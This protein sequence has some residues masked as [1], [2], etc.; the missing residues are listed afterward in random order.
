[1]T[2]N[3]KIIA[4]LTILIASLNVKAAKLVFASEKTPTYNKIDEKFIKY[5]KYKNQAV[6]Y[7][8]G[9]GITDKTLDF[10]NLEIYAGYKEKPRLW[11][12]DGW[13]TNSYVKSSEYS[14]GHLVEVY[15]AFSLGAGGMRKYKDNVYPTVLIAESPLL[16]KGLFF[17]LI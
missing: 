12:Y 8:D 4:S 3:R 2:L 6:E 17:L 13:K 5:V 10:E 16:P 14:S 15:R 7:S 1:M 9:I 11:V